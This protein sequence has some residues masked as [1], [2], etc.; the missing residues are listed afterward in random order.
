MPPDI[1]RDPHADPVPILTHGH[2]YRPTYDAAC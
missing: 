1:D 2:L